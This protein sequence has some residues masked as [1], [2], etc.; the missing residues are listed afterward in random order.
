MTINFYGVINLLF[1][2]LYSDKKTQDCVLKSLTLFSKTD[3]SCKEKNKKEDNPQ[4][5]R[6]RT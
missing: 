1:F 3:Q 4:K 6:V 2:L 5:R